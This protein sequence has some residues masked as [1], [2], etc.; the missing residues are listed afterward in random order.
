MLKGKCY[1]FMVIL[2]AVLVGIL[3]KTPVYAFNVETLDE[4]DDLQAVKARG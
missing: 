3:V 4:S 1:Y 2:A